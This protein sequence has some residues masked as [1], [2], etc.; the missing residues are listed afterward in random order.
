MAYI[1]IK[2]DRKNLTIMGVCFPDLETL[3]NT[4]SAVGSNMFEGFE[5]TAKGIAIIR[6]YITDKITIEDVIQKAKDKMYG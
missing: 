5:P 4:A 1:P 6:D 2:I 3:D